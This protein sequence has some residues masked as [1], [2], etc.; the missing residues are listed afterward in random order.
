[1][2]DGEETR[3]SG[4]GIQGKSGICWGCRTSD[5]VARFTA[6]KVCASGDLF[7]PLVSLDGFFL[8]QATNPNRPRFP[9]VELD[10][11]TSLTIA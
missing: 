9:G 6:T 2:T 4:S 11:F 7:Y 8:L 5:G 3:R 10:F 1:V